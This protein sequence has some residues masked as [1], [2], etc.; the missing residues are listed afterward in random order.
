MESLPDRKKVE[1]LKILFSIETVNEAEKLQSEL[2]KIT[3]EAL[4]ITKNIDMDYILEKKS[5]K[6]QNRA[7]SVIKNVKLFLPNVCLS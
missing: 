5:L 6:L 2:K 1:K 4:D 3:K 7:S